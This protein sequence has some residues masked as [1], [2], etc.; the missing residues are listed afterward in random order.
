MDQKPP[1]LSVADVKEEAQDVLISD[2]DGA[3]HS[4][5]DKKAESTVCPVFNGEVKEETVFQDVTE[6]KVT[7][8]VRPPNPESL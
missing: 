6:E 2:V 1:Q 7:G 5:P 3:G 8:S 4:S